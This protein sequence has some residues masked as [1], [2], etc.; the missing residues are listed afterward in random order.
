MYPNSSIK[1]RVWIDISKK[2][3]RVKEERNSLRT[4]TR[5]VNWIGHILHRNCL[6]KHIT[7]G[8]LQGRREMMG[9]Q[10]RRCKQ[11]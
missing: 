1:R 6:L 3:Y 9:R 5:K 2:D 7:E 8:K 4:I 10:R 11:I